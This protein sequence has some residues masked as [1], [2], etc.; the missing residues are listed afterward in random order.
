MH[1]IL[2]ILCVD[3]SSQGKSEVHEVVTLGGLVTTST[4]TKPTREFRLCSRINYVEVIRNIWR[5]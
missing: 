1:K 4:T 5:N 2:L 3:G